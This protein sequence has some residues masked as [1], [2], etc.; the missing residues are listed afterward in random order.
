MKKLN[1]NTLVLHRVVREEILNFEDIAEN[2]FDKILS[3]Y[4]KN[5]NFLT[6]ENAFSKNN[7][8]NNCICLTFDDG[9][10]SDID[11]VL[12]KLKENNFAATFFIVKNY[13]NKDG[14][15]SE[16]DIIELS[17]QGMQIG[18]HSISHPNFLKIDDS[19]KMNELI[20]SRKY[21]EDLTSK[22]ITTFS[23]P[24]G[25]ANSALINLV[26]DAGYEYCCT[27]QHGLAN[28]YSRI[29]PRNSINGSHSIRKV[30]QYMEPTFTTKTIW[31]IEDIM[32]SRLKAISPKFYK[33]LR[34]IVS[35][36]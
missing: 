29:I 4:S 16:E 24:F 18:S 19:K 12:P 36:R 9:F 20:S 7:L 3:N 14:Y 8:E 2:V 30:F 6:I 10:K 33:K 26:F 15:M 35:K 32:K 22:K 1:I 34:N 25:F 28:N 31:F 21:L 17:N 13:L 27:S 23:F 5:K 11:I